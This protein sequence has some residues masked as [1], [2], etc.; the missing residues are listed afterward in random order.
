MEKTTLYESRAERAKFAHLRLTFVLLTSLMCVVGSYSLS[1]AQELGGL[2]VTP[3]RIVFEG[4]HRS[5]EVNLV[6]TT[7]TPATYR[8]SFKN[9]RMLENGSYE[10]I[11]EPG[12]Y[13]LFADEMIRYS[14]RQVTL[15]PDVAQTIRLLLR[16]P[17]DLSPGEYRSHLMFQA[18]PPETAGEDIEQLDLEEGEIRVQIT[19]IFAITI[20]V[21][22]RHGKLSA[23][24]TVS[25]LA[26]IPSEKPDEPPALFLRLNRIGDRSVS[27]EVRVTFVS[28]KGGDELEVGLIR[29]LAVL[30]PYPTRTVKL[31]LRA[32]EGVVL[33]GGRLHVI[34]RARP[35]E[36]GAVLA[37][38]ELSL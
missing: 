17:G 6:N 27:G 5:A 15:E 37:E 7:S 21:I 2:S 33:E 4:R 32:P 25:D 30:A 35:E 29:G 20:P 3:T 38:A 24:V 28:D 19:T 18:L 31:T 14:P 26:L 13:E 11:D 1:T 9:M 23:T 10:D 34:Y 16:K 8:I 12:A 22:I 36:G